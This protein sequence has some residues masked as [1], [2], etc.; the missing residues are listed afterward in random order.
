MEA[1][2]KK[3]T[4]SWVNFEAF[5]QANNGARCL[6]KITLRHPRWMHPQDSEGPLVFRLKGVSP[7]SQEIN[8]VILIPVASDV[9]DLR[10]LYVAHQEVLRELKKHTRVIKPRIRWRVAGQPAL[11]FITSLTDQGNTMVS[12]Y[13]FMA[14]NKMCYAMVFSSTHRNNKPLSECLEEHQQESETLVD[15]LR[16]VSWAKQCW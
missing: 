8:D 6:S 3:R 4:R 1:E 12:T 7:R 5:A 16:S 15:M 10:D 9:S 14:H 2:L 13:V 11:G